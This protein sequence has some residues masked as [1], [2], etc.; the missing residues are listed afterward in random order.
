MLR[1]LS[2]CY[3]QVDNLSSPQQQAP[4]QTR[5]ANFNDARSVSLM[6]VCHPSP[7][8]RNA[9]NTSA[10]KRSLTASLVVADFGR[11]RAL[12]LAPSKRS[13]DLKNSA[14]NSGASSGSRQMAFVERFFSVICFPHADDAAH[15]VARCPNQ[16]HQTG[17]Q[18]ANGDESFFLVFK[19]FIAT[20]EINAL[21]H[22]G[23]SRKIQ[24]AL[25]QC[26]IAF[27]LVDSRFI[28]LLYPR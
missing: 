20:S 10:S 5:P 3:W 26:L 15:L 22:L 12:S 23:G 18:V 4:S 21:K 9:A 2:L 11:P 8:A 7:L 28:Y 25:A 17:I 27:I 1:R 13:A 19:S 16:H 14:V 24:S 6:R